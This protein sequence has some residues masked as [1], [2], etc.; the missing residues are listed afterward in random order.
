MDT[1]DWH[2]MMTHDGHMKSMNWYDMCTMNWYNIWWVNMTT[3][4][5]GQYMVM[6]YD[7]VATMHWCNIWRSIRPREQYIVIHSW[8]LCHNA[9]YGEAPDHVSNILWDTLGHVK[10]MYWY[11][12]HWATRPCE[13]Y[14]ES[15]DDHMKSANWYNTWRAIRPYGQY[16]VIHSTMWAIYCETL[17]PHEKYELTQHMMR[18][19]TTWA[20]YGEIHDNMDTMNW[21]NTW[22]ATRPCGHRIDTTHGETHNHMGNILR[23]HYDHMKSH[24][25]YIS[26]VC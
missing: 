26:N 5:R 21:Y 20:I 10:S 13:Q 12:T 17:W 1:V 19:S 25:C 6:H 9:I 14:I 18:H 11:N 22:W 8:P 23:G 3:W 24:S 7:K 15:H 2:H 16:M 4:P